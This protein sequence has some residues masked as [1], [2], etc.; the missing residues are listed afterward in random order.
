MELKVV[1][2][3]FCE[4]TIGG[5]NFQKQTPAGHYIWNCGCGA[6]NLSIPKFEDVQLTTSQK[7]MLMVSE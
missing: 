2:C 4:H 3:L 1:R 5:K 7:A 6:R